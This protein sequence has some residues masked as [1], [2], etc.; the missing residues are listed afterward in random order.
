MF[1][2]S[3]DSVVAGAIDNLQFDDE[4]FQQL[5]RPRLAILWRFG[6]AQR[7][8]FG[9]GGTVKDALSGRGWRMLA[10]QNGL[11]PFFHKLLAGPSNRIGAD[12]EGSRDLAVAPSL[13]SIQGVSLQQ[14]ASLGQLTGRMSS[15][16]D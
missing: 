6:T 14:D 11:K 13:T 3:P 8:Q 4:L 2:A 15:G 16:I 5:Q 12:I 7:D 10:H 1:F 9:F